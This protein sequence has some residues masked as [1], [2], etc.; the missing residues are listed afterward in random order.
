[1]DATITHATITQQEYNDWKEENALLRDLL[2]EQANKLERATFAIYQLL[3]DNLIE[4]SQ[5][6]EHE[7]RISYLE[8]MV[9]TLELK[10]NNLEKRGA[11][12]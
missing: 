1:M 9:K 4:P 10:I 6:D 11:K 5:D 3:K 8:E 12:N 7:K 2:I